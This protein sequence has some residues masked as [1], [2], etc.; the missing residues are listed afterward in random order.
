MKRVMIVLLF[1]LVITMLLGISVAS[2]GAPPDTILVDPHNPQTPLITKD[3]VKDGPP[4]IFVKTPNGLRPPENTPPESPGSTAGVPNY[5]AAN[6]AAH[7][8]GNSAHDILQECSSCGA[9]VSAGS[10]EC[11]ECGSSL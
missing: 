9:E 6:G 7:A 4:D 11:P 1:G 2:A 3:D 8:N 10:T 5:H